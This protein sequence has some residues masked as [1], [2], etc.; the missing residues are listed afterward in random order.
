MRGSDGA[1]KGP[2]L[3]K[4]TPAMDDDGSARS[5]SRTAVPDELVEEWYV[6]WYLGTWGEG[7]GR[8]ES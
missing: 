3:P 4:V 1:A 8:T 7:R 5:E 2:K 6:E